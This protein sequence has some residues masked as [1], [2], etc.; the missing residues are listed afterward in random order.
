MSITKSERDEVNMIIFDAEKT[1]LET[2][3]VGTSSTSQ[4]DSSK[5]KVVWMNWGKITSDYEATTLRLL[6]YS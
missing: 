6:G 1:N 3:S 2:P 4:V 5:L